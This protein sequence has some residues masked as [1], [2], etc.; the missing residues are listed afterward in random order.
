MLLICVSLS[1]YSTREI[2]RE[3]VCL[4]RGNERNEQHKV[5]LAYGTARK[6]ID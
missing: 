1:R 4:E 2:S 3:E 5:R 6:E